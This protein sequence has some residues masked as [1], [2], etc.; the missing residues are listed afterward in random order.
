MSTVALRGT[1]TRLQ[2]IVQAIRDLQQGRSNAHGAFT[3]TGDGAATSL[4]VTAQT[5]AAGSH[6]NVTPTTANAAALM[7]GLYTIA[8]DASFTVRHAATNDGDCTF[9]W[10]ING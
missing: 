4:V 5:C 6:V 9:T 1:E 10:S 2:R 8:A 7:T 3:L